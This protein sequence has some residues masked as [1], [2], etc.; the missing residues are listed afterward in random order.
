MRM[1]AIGTLVGMALSLAT[2]PA[3][4]A[5]QAAWKR[6]VSHPWG[7][8]FDAPGEVR[9]FMGGYRG[10]LPDGVAAG[11][12]TTIFRSMES[13]I[14]YKATVISFWHA[15]A[16]GANL[17]GE[18]EF[19]FQE[20]KTVLVDSFARADSGANAIYGRK[21]VADLPMNG[22]RVTAVHYFT[23]GKLF[24]FEAIVHPANGNYDSP[25]ATRF[26]DSV[27]FVLGPAQQGAI[28]LQL[29]E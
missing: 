20:N 5:S 21:T 13:G 10:G 4:A 11:H 22:G 24:T 16:E 17:L 18:R 14:E 15:Q 12:E 23:K 25:E 26:V 28:E 1:F 8:S 6:Y 29:P 27:T 2:A 9:T 7:F 19:F 3:E